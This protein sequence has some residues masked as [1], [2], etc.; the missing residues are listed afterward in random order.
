[1]INISVEYYPVATLL[2]DPELAKFRKVLTSAAPEVKEFLEA[3]DRPDVV[4]G[5]LL[6]PAFDVPGI[7]PAC[8]ALKGN[9]IF[10][11]AIAR[12]DYLKKC[13]GA[14]TKARAISLGL[15][16]TGRKGRVGHWMPG[17]TVAEVYQATD[18]VWS[19]LTFKPR[20]PKGPNALTAVTQTKKAE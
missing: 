17:F 2:A 4:M 7:V 6:S 14:I 5:M 8:L 10:E 12:N 16:P 19:V 13:L 18:A 15:V 20:L 9:K 1:M 11:N 3:L